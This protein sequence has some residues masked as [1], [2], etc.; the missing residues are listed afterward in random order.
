MSRIDFFRPWAAMLA[1]ILVAGLLLAAAFATGAAAQEVPLTGKT[2]V[3]DPGHGGS[4]SGA[5]NGTYGI[6]EKD[7]TLDVAYRLKALLEASGATVYMTR[8]GDPGNPNGPG[9]KDPGDDAFADD[10]TLS[11]NDRYTYANS[12]GASILVSIHMNGSSNASEDYTTTLFG[13]WRKDKELAHAVFGGLSTLPAAGA[14]GTIKTRTPYSYASGVLLKSNMPATIAETVFITS[15]AE[16]RLLS[17]GTG[18]RQQ[19]IAEALG[20]GIENYLSTH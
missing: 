13:K 17:D 5:V 8:G 11:N 1:A 16:G 10:A 7:Q 15:N 4:D 19:Q 18:T 12:T 2:V 9:V 20:T 3:L 6:K 14:A